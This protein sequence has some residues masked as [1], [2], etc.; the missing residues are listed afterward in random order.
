M[1]SPGGMLTAKPDAPVADVQTKQTAGAR[2]FS[3]V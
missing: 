3:G 1:S 2:K